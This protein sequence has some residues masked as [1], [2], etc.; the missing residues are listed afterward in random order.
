MNRF[1]GEEGTIIGTEIAAY[2]FLISERKV[3]PTP[4]YFRSMTKYSN[5]RYIICK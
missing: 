1:L 5:R 3:L 2:K 4:G